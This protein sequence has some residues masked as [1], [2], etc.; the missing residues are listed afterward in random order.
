[1]A[2]AKDPADK[3]NDKTATKPTDDR[4]ARYNWQAGDIEIH[5]P[6]TQEK[7]V[8]SEDEDDSGEQG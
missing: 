1:M 2:K 5:P 4:A 8:E 7:D 6:E 3:A